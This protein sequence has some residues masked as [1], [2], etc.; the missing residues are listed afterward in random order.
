[1]NANDLQ[2]RIRTLLEPSLAQLG[3]DLV[4][5]EWVGGGHGQIL[6]LSIDSAAGVNADDCGAVS[7]AVSPVLDA[8]DPIERAY[9]LEVSSPGIDRPVQRH[10][11]FDRFVGYRIKIKLVEGHPRRRYTGSLAGRDG[12]EIT[13]TVDGTDHRILL[14]TVERANLVLDLAQYKELAK[15]ITHDDQ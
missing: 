15:E 3:F 9:T 2:E 1:M 4:A 10:E 8:E 11:D 12:D 5:V 14:A 7:D 6:R 13:V